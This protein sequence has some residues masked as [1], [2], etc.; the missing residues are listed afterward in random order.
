MNAV[1]YCENGELAAMEFELA[2]TKLI[3]RGL[4]AQESRM[5]ASGNLSQVVQWFARNL[6]TPL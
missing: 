1:M 2:L 3:G 6:K 5:L 4:S